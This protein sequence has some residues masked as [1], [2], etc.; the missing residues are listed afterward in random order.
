MKKLLLLQIV[1]LSCLTIKTSAQSPQGIS[2]QAVARNSSG[3]AVAGEAIDV[4]FSIWDAASGGTAVFQETHTAV[5]TNLYGLFNLVI[6]SVNTGA[7]SSINW[8]AGSKYLEVEVDDGSGFTS[9]GRIQMQSVPYA[10]Y[11]ASAGGGVAGATGNTGATGATGAASTVAGPAGVTGNTGAN[12]VTGATGDAGLAGATGVTGNT[13]AAGA[14]GITGSTGANGPTGLAGATGATGQGITSITDNMNGTL[15]ITYGSGAGITTS[16]LYGSTG[17]TGDAGVTGPTGAAGSAGETGALGATGATGATGVAGNDGAKGET[18][19]TGP[20]GNAGL[21]GV[22]GNTG[23]TGSTGIAGNTGVT[24][25]TGATGTTGLTG[26]TGNT[27]ATGA[28]GTAGNTGATGSTGATGNI[29]LTGITGATGVAGIT[30]ATGTTGDTGLLGATGNTG[31]TG[32]TGSTGIVGNT[33]STGATGMTGATGDT[34]LMGPTGPSGAWTLSSIAYNTSGTVTV[35]GTTGSGG[36]I[37]SANAA[38]LTTGNTGTTPG[39]NYIGTADA[40]D[41]SVRVNA[42]TEMIRLGAT[43]S[44]LWMGMTSAITG[45]GIQARAFGNNLTVN[46]NQATAM[47]NFVQANHLGSFAIGDWSNSSPALT[48]SSAMDEMTMRFAGG[49]RFFTSS[50]ISA[51]KGIYFKAGGNVGIGTASP[52]AQLDVQGN[53]TASSGIVANFRTN[54]SGNNDPALVVTSPNVSA[55]FDGPTASFVNSTSSGIPPM[56]GIGIT[57]PVSPLHIVTGMSGAYIINQNTGSGNPHGL[58]L[59][60]SDRDWYLVANLG[61]AA[62]GNISIYDATAGASRFTILPSGNIGIGTVA[63]ST[64]L[65]VLD[66]TAGGTAAYFENT[67]SGASN[68]VGLFAK[69]LNSAGYGIAAQFVAGY[70]GVDVSVTPTTLL[71]SSYAMNVVNSG[72]VAGTHYGINVSA[73]STLGAN[74]GVYASASGGLTNYAVYSNGPQFSTSGSAWT[75]SDRR[76]KRDIQDLS[77]NATATIAKIKVKQYYFDTEKYKQ[78]NLPAEL[79]W[80]F[81]AQDMEQIIPG[82]VKESVHPAQYDPKT[83][84]KISDEVDLKVIQY[85]KLFPLLVKSA[86]EQEAVIEKQQEQIGAMQ[87]QLEVQQQQIDALLKSK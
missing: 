53:G 41:L 2:Y 80:G 62:A 75:V 22:A 12:G 36:P 86:Q 37:T 33:G 64:R 27:G 52:G 18:G 72:G 55:K 39:V 43:N 9:M 35:N 20:T 57:S 40:K 8:S 29:G 30:G 42:S 24:G 78:L 14:N 65:Q 60:S 31:A 32:A 51:G 79:Q 5:T 45:S 34:G 56:V 1:F 28:T 76:L 84:E 7:F 69:A 44:Q 13:G 59:L 61:T 74:Y 63:P 38:W 83:K 25:S 73:T 21:T 82:M 85:D 46:G 17:S 19:A 48:Q 58:R 47:G 26:V 71:T 23:A 15:T 68:G 77:I 87:K 10:L 67:Y 54:G 66:P 4:R 81:I 3:G 70:E 50:D 49:Y 6:G 11:A 16:S